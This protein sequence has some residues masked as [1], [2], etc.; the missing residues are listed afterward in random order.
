[1]GAILRLNEAG[2]RY[3][4]VQ[5]GSSISKGRRRSVNQGE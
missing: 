1:V 2:L 5:Y 3:L 4:L